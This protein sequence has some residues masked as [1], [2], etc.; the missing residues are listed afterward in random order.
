MCKQK[1]RKNYVRISD[2]ERALNGYG[3]NRQIKKCKEYLNL[4]DLVEDSNMKLCVDDGYSGK[5]MDRPAMRELLQEINDGQV[6][7]V[8]IYKLIST[9]KKCHQCI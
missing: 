7:L 1:E 5:S 4:Y 2:R 6:D 8:I 9:I 3:L